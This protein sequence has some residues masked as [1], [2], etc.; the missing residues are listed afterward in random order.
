MAIVEEINDPAGLRKR[1]R[2]SNP[3]TLEHICDMEC[4]THDEVF[5]AVKKARLVQPMWAALSFKERARYMMKALEI[6]IERQEEFIDVVLRETPKPRTQAILMD[7]WASCDSLNYYAKKSQKCLKTEIVRPHGMLAFMKQLK[8]VY[9]PLGVVGIVSPWNEPFFLSINP[10]IQALMAG[11]AV[12]LKPSSVTPYSG[13]LVG[14]LFEAAG[15]P[16]GVLQ[17]ILGDGRA[18]A[19]LIEAGVDKI[20]FTGSVE[21]GRKVAVACAERFIPCTLELGGKDPMIVCEDANLEVAAGGALSAAF[22]NG[23]QVCM[24]AERVYV[25]D[26]VADEFI[27]KVVEKTLKLRQ[28][29]DGEFE[30]GAMY[31]PD[32]IKIIERHMEDAIAKGAK[33]LCGGRRNPN[34]K[35]FYFEP[36][37][38]TDVTHDMLIMREETFGPILPIVRVRDEEEAIKLANDTEFGL[39]ATV[40]SRS[41]RRSCKIAER[42]HAGSVCIN[43]QSITY[44]AP[45]APFGGRKESGIGQVNGDIGL[46]GFCYAQPIL[47]DR[48]GGRMAIQGFPYSFKK[49]KLF[50]R[51]ISL[52]WAIL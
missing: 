7:I 6:L 46:R 4:I 17:V 50:Q 52:L 25:M 15:L 14:D 32:Q 36:T 26:P 20:S 19:A 48:F 18:G 28:S 5:E 16:E 44:G 23:G 10:T 34:L 37:V 12:L 33:V 8:I 39:S 41:N 49:D 51:L 21:T 43:D 22:L 1:I 29:A 13:K 45:E 40:W 42:I 31:W 35:G 38:M 30:V 27:N 2:L 24:A 47:I 3:A 11:N 9:H